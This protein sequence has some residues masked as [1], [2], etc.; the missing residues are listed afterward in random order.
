MHVGISAV[1]RAPC[2]RRR[3]E[4]RAASSEQLGAVLG[5]TGQWP[6]S[7]HTKPQ[8][9]RALARFKANNIK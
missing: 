8:D 4:Q 7:S 3:C 9:S 5:E 6:A 1:R 2:G